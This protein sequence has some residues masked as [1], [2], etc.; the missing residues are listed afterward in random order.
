MTSS[1]N[2]TWFFNMAVKKYLGGDVLP[3]NNNNSSTKK[4]ESLYD[5][6]NVLNHT[7][8]EAVIDSEKGSLQ[9]LQ[10]KIKIP[11]INGGEVGEHPTQ[12]L[13]DVF[14]IREEKNYCK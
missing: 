9:E 12:A 2:K 11:V 4:G 5:T 3:L 1:K 14:T 6:L 7:V 10:N 8:I 13:S